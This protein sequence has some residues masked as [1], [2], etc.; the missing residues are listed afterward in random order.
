MLDP[1]RVLADVVVGKVV[2]C[3]VDHPMVGPQAGLACADDALIGV[4]SHKQASVDQERHDSLDLHSFASV[5]DARRFRS[6]SGRPIVLRH[7]DAVKRS[8]GRS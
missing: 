4:D 5:A 3:L 7:C 2:D 6:R 8:R 1:R